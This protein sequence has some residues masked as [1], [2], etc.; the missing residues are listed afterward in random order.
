MTDKK[1]NCYDCI[2]RGTV[3]GDCHSS[4]HHPDS[5][6]QASPLAAAL[7]IFSGVREPEPDS[8]RTPIDLKVTANYHGIKN[9][10]FV[11]PANFDPT[12]LESCNGFEE[13]E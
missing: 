4:C 11:W 10:W 1:P 2:H 8:D 3:P 12:W 5:L 9:G 7:A 13:S 6:S